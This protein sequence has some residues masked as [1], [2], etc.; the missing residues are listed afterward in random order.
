M[1]RSFATVLV[2]LAGA[3]AMSG[4]VESPIGPVHFASDSSSDLSADS[5]PR[6]DGLAAEQQA[7]VA[8]AMGRFEAHGLEL[9]EVDFIFHDDLLVCDGHKGRYHSSTRTL[10]M[11]SMDPITMLHEL[12]HAWANESLSEAARQDFLRWRGLESWNDHDVPWDQRGT[13]HVAETIA[14]GLAVEPHHVKWL[15]TLPDGSHRTT[16]RILTLG[17]D[18]ETLVKNFKALTGMD[19]V[20]R[21]PDEWAAEEAELAI[22]PEI[23]QLG[24]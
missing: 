18:V 8:Q 21:H 12:A 4:S 7:L 15:E 24:T 3:L 13:E 2:A 17:I 19:P 9:P 5:E 20:F 14:W 22:S 10:E 6:S 23:G 11:C 16:H 1:A